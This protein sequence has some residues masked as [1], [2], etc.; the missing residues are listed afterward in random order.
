MLIMRTSDSAK[1]QTDVFSSVQ[2]GKDRNR[3]TSWR[4]VCRAEL[5]ST[6]SCS[7]RDDDTNALEIAE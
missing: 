1:A 3:Q 2:E 5:V 7:F 4:K 6:I